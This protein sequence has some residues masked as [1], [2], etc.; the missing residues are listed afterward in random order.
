MH[1]IKKSLSPKLFYITTPAA[2]VGASPTPPCIYPCISQTIKNIVIL[3]L[4][5]NEN[6]TAVF[7]THWHDD[8]T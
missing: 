4:A 5:L 2:P 7:M 6:D 3:F 8:C 1:C